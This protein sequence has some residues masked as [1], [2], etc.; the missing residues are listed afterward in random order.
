[1]ETAPGMPSLNALLGDHWEHA[2]WSDLPVP[3][4]PAIANMHPAEA[5]RHLLLNHGYHLID[6]YQLPAGREVYLKELLDRHD[7]DHQVPAGY[8][9]GWDHQHA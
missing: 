2:D 3:F 5:A 7:K 4:I 6:G 9:T 8:R 1:M